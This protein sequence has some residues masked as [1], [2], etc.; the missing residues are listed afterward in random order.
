MTERHGS[1]KI[2]ENRL[3]PVRNENLGW[4][5]ESHHCFFC[6]GGKGASHTEEERHGGRRRIKYEIRNPERV[7]LQKQ[8]EENVFKRRGCGQPRQMALA[9][10]RQNLNFSRLFYVMFILTALALKFIF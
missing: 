8:R 7:M 3:H 10:I 6:D 9:F 1:G 4:K 5:P 2:R